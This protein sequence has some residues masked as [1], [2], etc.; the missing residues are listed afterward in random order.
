MSMLGEAAGTGKPLYVFDMGDGDASWWTLPHNYRYKP[1][2]FR[3]AMAF[4]PERMRRDIGRIQDALVASGR[5]SWLTPG[6]VAQAAAH[7][8][9]GS[10][11]G[12]R[13]E[14]GV[15]QDELGR[16]AEAVRRLLTSR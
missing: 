2:S 16:T 12:A 1:L 5:A 7:L 13:Q 11:A 9:A 14:A 4:G 10:T 3:A 6:S 15:A 8:Q